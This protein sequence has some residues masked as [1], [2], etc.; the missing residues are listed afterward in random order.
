MPPSHRSR[1]QDPD[2]D[3]FEDDDLPDTGTAQ[4]A[5]QQKMK[6]LAFELL[7]RWHW[8]VLGLVLGFLGASYYLTKTPKQYTATASLLIKQQTSTVMARDQIDEIDLRSMEAM[9]TVAERIGR[10]DLLER[11]ASRRDVRDLVG[12]MPLTVDWMPEW[13]RNKIGQEFLVVDSAKQAPPPAASLGGM[14]AGWLQISIRRGTRLL[15]I[16][17]THPVPEVSK[18]LTDA[19]ARE[20]LAEIAN[21][22][23]EG[24]SN[25]IDLLEKESKEARLSLQLAG[26]ALA[27]YSRT[28]EVHKALD[29][30]EEEVSTLQRRYLPQHPKMIA[31]AAKLKQLQ[32]QFLREFDVARQAA[33][34]KAYWEIADKE[35]PDRQMQPEEHLR[36]ARQQLLARIGVLQSEIQSATTVFNSMLTRIKESS[37]NQES[38]ESSAEVSNLA[39]VPGMPSAPVANKVL[40]LGALGGLAF[41]LLL[42]L[43]FIRLDNKF[44]TVS[45]IIGETGG[46]ILAAIADIQ[47]QHLAAS[48]QQ[49]RKAHPDAK[50]SADKHWNQR[51]IFREG[52]SSTIYAEMF[53][54]LR[55]SVSLLGDES[56]RKVTLFSSSLP[57][58]GKTF[59]SSNFAAA[60]AGQGRRTLL[61]DLDLRRPSI[62]KF[63]AREREHEHGGI[64][65][66]LAN[67]CTFDDAI[68]R[69][70]GIENLHL[71]LSGKQAPNP[72]ELLDAGRLKI[73]I[74]Q[75]CRDY[76]V[77]VLDTSPLLAVP[78]TRL[79]A[80][81]ADNVCLVVRANYGPKGALRRVLEV[82]DHDGTKLSGIIFNGFK[83]KRHLIG[84]NYSYGYY[85]TS[86]FGRSY[87]YG[88]GSYGAYGSEKEK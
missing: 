62:H 4:Q 46:T 23:T 56:R 33:N 82:M 52:P 19:I 60:A 36:I 39:R 25:S 54:V 69:D 7:G 85:K 59:I 77:V 72:G 16:S 57:G 10:A 48:E 6:R 68:I 43:L 3:D 22:R 87:R 34:D 12:L 53:R 75:A 65:E 26:S 47:L 32:E 55:A 78:D 18:A 45:Q 1:R 71:I 88:Y 28:L 50:E 20:Y 84:E 63:F 17:I 41:G 86:R 79:I 66:C 27:I 83:E 49:Y 67:L 8:L 14:I 5:G 2:L 44:H 42:A 74:A 9:N 21:A 73:I 40:A 24:R 37:V 64:T 61:I 35:R 80:P 30:S 81:L 76:D 58:E 51:L 11:V 70:S 29:I 31:S 13:L 38:A 15:D